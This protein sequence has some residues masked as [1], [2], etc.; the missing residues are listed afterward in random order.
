M[1]S[2]TCVTY[3]NKDA[4]HLQ[5]RKLHV[6]VHTHTPVYPQGSVTKAPGTLGSTVSCLYPGA[7][8]ERYPPIEGGASPFPSVSVAQQS[9]PGHHFSTSVHSFCFVFA[10]LNYHHLPRKNFQPSPPQ[11]CLVFPAL[12]PFPCPPGGL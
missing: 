3:A 11:N 8:A 10:N 9:A 2:L 4:S 1:F 5:G 12:Q 6:C 7:P